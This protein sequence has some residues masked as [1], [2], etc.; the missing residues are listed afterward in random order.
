MSTFSS[1]A[2]PPDPTAAGR[3]AARFT[4]AWK[5]ITTMRLPPV[6]LNSQVN[7]TE[8]PIVQPMN[9]PIAKAGLV[10]ALSIS[11]WPVPKTKYRGRCQKPQT[12]PR[13]MLASNAFRCCCSRGRAK[14][15]QPSSS[16][17]GPPRNSTRTNSASTT[18]A[19]PNVTAGR[20][21]PKAATETAIAAAIIAKGST[22]A[23]TVQRTDSRDS[24]NPASRRR[25]SL[26][27]NTVASTSAAIL[28]PAIATTLRAAPTGVWM[29]S[30]PSI[31][32]SQM[33][34]EIANVRPK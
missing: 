17:T 21:A 15:R 30:D 33:A 23:T 32:P 25:S 19:R 20:G 24:E 7:N 13:R 28:G 2:A 29:W 11:D 12:S 22:S 18:P 31:R 3:N 1:G 14:P 4:A 26:R 34:Q 5:R 6:W 16:S 10:P 27:P 9:P 8:R